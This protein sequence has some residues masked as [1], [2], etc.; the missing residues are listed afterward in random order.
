MTCRSRV[1]CKKSR[2]GA[3]Q[4][5][6]KAKIE[7]S[8]PAVYGENGGGNPPNFPYLFPFFFICSALFLENYTREPPIT[9]EGGIILSIQSS[10]SDL[11]K[12]RHLQK[13]RVTERHNRGTKRKL[14]SHQAQNKGL[15][16]FLGPGGATYIFAVCPDCAAP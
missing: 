13:S 7:V 5:A 8:P 15:R 9:Q 14:K 11:Q 1:I 2:H 12:S 10:T 4:S 6:H 3:A 16:A